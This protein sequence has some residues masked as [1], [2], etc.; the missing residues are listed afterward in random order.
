M[1]KPTRMEDQLA[2]LIASINR[3]LEEELSE[4]LRPEGVPLEQFRILSALSSSDGRSMRDLAAVVLVDPG[5]L[6]KIVDRMVTD[7]LVYR[8]AAPEDRRKVLI[9]LASKGKSI[10]DKLQGL[11]STQQQRLL[12]R[13]SGGKA[14]ELE[15]L[16]RGVINSRP[17]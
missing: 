15:H 16:L 14:Q 4:N 8:A 9:F 17:S 6:T 2:Y 1:T 12:E 10:H 7:A 3:Q 13:L 11:Y 5:S